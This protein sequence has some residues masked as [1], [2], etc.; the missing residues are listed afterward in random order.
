VLLRGVRGAAWA[1]VLPFDL[2]S[3]R[4]FQLDAAEF[5]SSL[6]NKR[7]APTELGENGANKNEAAHSATWPAY[8]TKHRMI[9]FFLTRHAFTHEQHAWLCARVPSITCLL[10]APGLPWRLLLAGSSWRLLSFVIS[11]I[12]VPLFAPDQR[13]NTG[14]ICGVVAS[15]Q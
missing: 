11:A 7:K 3:F 8:L 2:S 13:F 14:S 12:A 4:C 15:L 1:W 9:P 6:T 5:A 10:S